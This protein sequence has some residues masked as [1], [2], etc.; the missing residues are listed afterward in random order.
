MS[1]GHQG[2]GG[3]PQFPQQPGWGFTPQQAQ[4][5]QQPQPMGGG[6]RSSAGPGVGVTDE[7]WFE[8]E[9][10]FAG[11]PLPNRCACCC[12]PHEVRR[13]VTHTVTVG[14]TH[15]TRRMEIPYC[16][17]CDAA[18]REGSRRGLWLGLMGLA[19]AAAFPFVLGFLWEY[20]PAPV[21]FVGTPVVALAALYLLGTLWKEPP[22]ARERGA[23]SGPRDAVWMLPFDVGAN[24]TR[25]AG[26]NEA[27]LRQLAD[28]HHV[29]VAPRGRRKASAA[30]YVAVPILAALA[31]IP[32]WFSLH[33]R[34]YFDN[35]TLSPLTFDVDDGS[36][37]ITVP[38]GGHDD[39]YLPHGR[40]VVRVMVNGA[41]AD[42][43]EGEVE[44]F[45]K[46]VAT[47]FGQTCYATLTTSYGTAS[48]VGPREQMAAQ[49]QRW[50]TLERV[51]HVLEPFP[52]SVSVG[53]GQT[54]ATRKRFTRVHCSNGAPLL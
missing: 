35:P 20:A 27:W 10:P 14:R 22:I 42:R 53:Q 2:F 46:H 47:P 3:P 29:T 17:A 19:A 11:A 37:Q 13:A 54:G 43:I 21:T 36:A 6:Y 16:R 31:A 15:Y 18:A 45:G 44:H 51:Q 50:Y 5:F 48:V 28:M 41:A 9:V 4:Q 40:S 38:A 24:A 25:L 26:T 32:A 52:R 33:G 39:L 49:G 23:S 12:G 34:V 8:V 30:R 7:T 1:S